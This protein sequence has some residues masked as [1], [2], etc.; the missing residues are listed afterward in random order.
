MTIVKTMGD[1][2]L[3]EGIAVCARVSNFGL[4]RPEF[5]RDCAVSFVH[6]CSRS[7]VRG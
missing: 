5:R 2:Q 7:S 4:N 6:Y 1:I 3:L